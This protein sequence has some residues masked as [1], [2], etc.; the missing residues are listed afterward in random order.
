MILPRIVLPLALLAC[1]ACGQAPDVGPP[2]TEAER[3]APF[4][5]LLPIDRLIA[6][7]R[8]A[9]RITAA[10]TATLSARI[11][12]LRARAAQLSGPVVS[13]ATRAIMRAGV[14]RRAL[15]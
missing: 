2:L 8:P 14:A 6:I 11:A 13:P 15:R 7:P 1:F 12:N 4:P 9:P 5:S 3:N 10:S